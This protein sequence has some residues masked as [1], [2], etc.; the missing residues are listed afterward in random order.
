[1]KFPD[2]INKRKI[3]ISPKCHY[4]SNNGLRT[5]SRFPAPGLFRSGR[6][7]RYQPTDNI[8]P[9]FE[10]HANIRTPTP[11]PSPREERRK[12]ANQ[13][14]RTPRHSR[15][16][17]FLERKGK[18]SR[19]R[20]ALRNNGDEDGRKKNIRVVSRKRKKKKEPRKKNRRSKN[21]IYKDDGI[22]KLLR[23]DYDDFPRCDHLCLREKNIILGKKY[24]EKCHPK[25]YQGCNEQLAFRKL[26]ISSYSPSLLPFFLILSFLITKIEIP[27]SCT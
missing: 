16:F 27:P 13:F 25:T 11:F 6:E 19:Y 17:L 1:M 5:G 15:A 26:S 7:L 24:P 14:S 10:T 18:N 23:V 3:I 21:M 22:E 4:N 2:N 8:K 9:H 12:Q 20:N